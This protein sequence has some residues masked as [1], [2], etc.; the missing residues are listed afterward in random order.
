VTIRKEL[1]HSI[2]IG[3]TISMELV[4]LI[5]MC[6]SETYTEVRINKHV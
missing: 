1:L 4:R 3:F 5:K 2:Q 6:L